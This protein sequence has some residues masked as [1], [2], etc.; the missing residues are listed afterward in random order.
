MALA[1][2]LWWG[3]NQDL[4]LGDSAW[5]PLTCC[6]QRPRFL[7]WRAPPSWACSCPRIWLFPDQV[8]WGG[9]RGEAEA[10]HNLAPIVADCDFCCTLFVRSK[11]PSPAGFQGEEDEAPLLKGGVSRN[12]WTYFKRTTVIKARGKLSLF[13]VRKTWSI[14]RVSI[15]LIQYRCG[16]MGNSVMGKWPL[17]GLGLEIS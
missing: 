12:L 3:C 11:S 4:G 10:F 14:G 16:M 1:Q 7:T 2:G 15:N 9:K 6:W 17:M 5:S 8:I 13:G